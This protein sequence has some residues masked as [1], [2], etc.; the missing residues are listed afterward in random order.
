MV[1]FSRRWYQPH[2]KR[3]VSLFCYNMAKTSVYF[4]DTVPT[5]EDIVMIHAVREPP[6]VYKE[7]NVPAEPLA[8]SEQYA[9]LM[10][11][12]AERKRNIAGEK[13]LT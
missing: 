12:V 8:A 3:P 1:L 13:G 6:E 2:N 4:Y 7:E 11:A 5:V 9:A 10:K